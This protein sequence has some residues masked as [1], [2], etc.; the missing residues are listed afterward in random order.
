MKRSLCF[1][2]VTGVRRLMITMKSMLRQLIMRLEHLCPSKLEMDRGKW[3]QGE[4]EAKQ[5]QDQTGHD[6]P[7]HG[8][9][10]RGRASMADR[11]E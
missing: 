6:C 4:G 9:W 7:V 10:R 8:S 5:T 2:K 11:R 3:S 1:V